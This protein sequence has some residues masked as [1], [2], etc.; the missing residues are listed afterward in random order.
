[1][2][3]ARKGT[4]I[5]SVQL[6]VKV[7]KKK[8]KKRGRE[9]VRFNLYQILYRMRA[10]TAG[11]VNKWTVGKQIGSLLKI[12]LSTPYFVLLFHFQRLIRPLIRSL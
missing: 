8:E 1:M 2:F 4:L 7:K 10:R 5:F 3:Q 6:P 12:I 9:K 11:N